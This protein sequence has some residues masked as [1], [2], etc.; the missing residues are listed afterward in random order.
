MNTRHICNYVLVFDEDLQFSV[1]TVGAYYSE[2][3]LMECINDWRHVI[4]VSSFVMEEG[5]SKHPQS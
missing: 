3:V 5:E 1:S 2:E 4:K